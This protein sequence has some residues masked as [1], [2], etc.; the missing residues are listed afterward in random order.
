YSGHLQY[1]HEFENGTGLMEQARLMP[2]ARVRK[3]GEENL[4]LGGNLI[5]D[6]P[7]LG[8]IQAGYDDQYGAS[9]GLGFNLTKNISLGDS[10]DRGM[11]KTFENF[12]LSHEV[13]LAYSFTPIFTEDRVLLE[14]EGVLVQNENMPKDSLNMTEKDKE[15]AL[16]Q[17]K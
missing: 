2:L 9:A 12:G 13:S 3:V 5:L 6:L 17:Q 4:T 14:D 8:W 7:K 15:I 10:W 16:L 11:S 1:T